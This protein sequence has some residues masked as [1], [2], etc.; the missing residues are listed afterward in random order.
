MLYCNSCNGYMLVFAMRLDCGFHATHLPSH[1]CCQPC[2]HACVLL[3]WFSAVHSKLAKLVCRVFLIN[4]VF[5]LA[6]A[7]CIVLDVPKWDMHCSTASR[8]NGLGCLPW[9]SWQDTIFHDVITISMTAYFNSAQYNTL[10]PI[11]Y[12]DRDAYLPNKVL[13]YVTKRRHAF[14]TIC[15]LS[16]FG[17]LNTKRRSYTMRPQRNCRGSHITYVGIYWFDAYSR[18]PKL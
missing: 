9:D 14:V 13:Y 2:L 18:N 11:A 12:S 4:G 6:L 5:I 1:V 17:R 8:I 16:T 3:Q 10:I 15:L 7:W